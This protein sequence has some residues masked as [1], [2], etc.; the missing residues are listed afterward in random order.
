MLTAVILCL[1]GLV[2]ICFA[3]SRLVDAAVSI[4]V[5]IGIPQ[6]V[7]GA[8]IVSICTALP[9]ILVS[10]VATFVGSTAISVGNALGSIICNTGLITG[11]AILIR[12]TKQGAVKEISWRCIFFFLVAG[13][14][15]VY[16]L[17]FGFYH[18]LVGIILLA[19]CALYFVLNIRLSKN[20][21]DETDS[22]STESIQTSVPRNIIIL[23][24]CA[25][26]LFV[27]ARLL[28]NNG[29]L[30]AELLGVPERIIAITFI[31]LGTSLPEL[32]TTIA[33]LIKKYSNI[34][35]G[36]IIGANLL[37][38]LLVIG[39]PSTF[40]TVSLEKSSLYMDLPVAIAVML[41][42]ALPILI[43]K[44][45]SRIQGAVLIGV[46]AVY[47]AVLLLL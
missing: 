40:A 3:G 10:S 20:E 35:L 45:T 1:I 38:L 9:E 6:I 2:L 43:R 14:L 24:V 30:L 11:L 27:G 39:I 28:V 26:L 12:P 47:T 22:V 7:V 37:N 32:V 41:I 15:L 33:S 21:T 4:S 44:R 29:T 19:L 13:F 25:F 46:Y 34:G 16:G 18:T 31:A 5:V 36:T 17:V 42:L 8:S 23:T